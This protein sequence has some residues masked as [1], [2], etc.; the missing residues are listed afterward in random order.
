MV[1][2][3]ISFHPSWLSVLWKFP[4]QSEV[5]RSQGSR[6]TARPRHRFSPPGPLKTGGDLAQHWRDWRQLWDA[7]ETVVGLR[8]EDDDYMY[9]IAVFIQSI[10]QPALRSA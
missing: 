9:R 7:Y 5:S 1:T 3:G 10:G 2:G 8:A 6:A 4:E